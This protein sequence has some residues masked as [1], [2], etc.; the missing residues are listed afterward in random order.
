MAIQK[1]GAAAAAALVLVADSASAAIVYS[2]PLN[3]AIPVGTTS[4]VPRLWVDLDTFA[5]STTASF[6]GWDI[7][8]SGSNS[9]FLTINSQTLSNNRFVGTGTGTPTPIA[10]LEVGTVIGASSAFGTNGGGSLLMPTYLPAPG[11]I[12]ANSENIIGFRRV[13][14]GLTI[15]GWISVLVGNDM[16]TRSVTGIAYEGSGAAIEAGAIPAPGALALLGL[17]GLISARRRR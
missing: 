2:G 14:N 5:T 12:L 4:P 9:T 1:F 16:L 8:F 11:P 13:V 10:R 7:S 3:L 17:G 6:T 15:Y